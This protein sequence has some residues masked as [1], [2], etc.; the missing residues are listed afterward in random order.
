MVNPYWNS[1]TSVFLINN[2]LLHPILPDPC[3]AAFYI[4]TPSGVSLVFLLSNHLMSIY[5]NWLR[6]QSMKLQ[7]NCSNFFQISKHYAD[8]KVYECVSPTNSLGRI[9]STSRHPLRPSYKSIWTS[10]GNSRGQITTTF[11]NVDNWV[12]PPKSASF[13]N[14][15]IAQMINATR[16]QWAGDMLV[17]KKCSRREGGS[18]TH[19]TIPSGKTKANA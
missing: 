11:R 2:S 1:E 8:E 16:I 13:L 12:F 10:R 19:P 6:L 5:W 17:W 15:I 7:W 4:H 3:D 14:A 18:F 9:V